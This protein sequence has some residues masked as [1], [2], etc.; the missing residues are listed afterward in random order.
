MTADPDETT[1]APSTALDASI[2]VAALLS[3]HE[4]HGAA[5][6]LLTELLES[7]ERIILPLHALAETYSVMTRLPA[8]HRLSPRDALQV[9]ERTL[10]ARASVIGLNGEEGWH[11]LGDLV[12]SSI[13][14]GTTYD[15]LILASARKGQA[16]RILTLNPS[17]FER[18]GVDGIEIVTP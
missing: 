7:G 13:S 8:P 12:R 2:L 5:S 17:H 4:R 15:G 3:W 11:C 16:T 1:I 18:L 10:R 9:L 14:G 6:G